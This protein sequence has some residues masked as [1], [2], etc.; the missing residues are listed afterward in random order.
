MSEAVRLAHHD[1]YSDRRIRTILSN[2]R[3]IAMVG[4]SAL[5][6]RPSYYAMKY[7][8][9][10]GYR[11]IPVNPTRAGAELLGENVYPDI[12]SIPGNVDMVDI[13]R[14]SE[15]AVD[16]AKDVIANREEKGIE[17]LWMQLSVRNDEAAR[18][19]EEG[20]LVVVMDRCPKIEY[21][22]LSGELGW[23]GIN[24]G[25]VTAKSLRPPRA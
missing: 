4:A 12:A 19:A 5:W 2:V 24:S 3:T 10:R 18:L 9:K 6:R 15:E 23:S 14:P 7:L 8:Q 1:D 25:I 11:V 21:A 20:G 17:V 22:R 16:I 13:F